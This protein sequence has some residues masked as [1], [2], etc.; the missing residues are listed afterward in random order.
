MK[1]INLYRLLQWL[2]FLPIILPLCLLAGALQGALG[3]I[4]RVFDQLWL[5]VNFRSNDL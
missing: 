5:D 3:M 2:F 1:R 4:E